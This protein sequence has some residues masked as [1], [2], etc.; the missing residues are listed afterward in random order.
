MTSSSRVPPGELIGFALDLVGQAGQLTERFFRTN[1]LDIETKPDGTPVTVADKQAE[2]LIRTAIAE[3]FPN[4]A[5]VGEEFGVTAAGSGRE[6][7]I[8]PIDGTKSFTAG[9]PLYANLL[10][11]IDEG[12]PVLGIIHLPALG[13]TVWAVAG[14][15]ATCNDEPCRVSDHAELDGAYAMTSGVRYWPHG[16]LDRLADLGVVLRTWGD[17]YGYALVATGRAEAMIDPIAY[18][19]DLAP[20]AVILNE[21]GGRFSDLAGVNTITSDNGVGTNGAI[22]EALLAELPAHG[23]D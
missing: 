11:V 21:A 19:W 20:M 22:H 2:Q 3:E 17:A 1:A 10:A 6:W 12:R 7:V 16:Y 18:K 15:G 14:A 5:I 8:D 9:V 4:D 23:R 13:E